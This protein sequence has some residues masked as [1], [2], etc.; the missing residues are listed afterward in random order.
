MEVQWGY[1]ASLNVDGSR[2]RCMEKTKDQQ[3]NNMSVAQLLKG[4]RTERRTGAPSSEARRFR[5]PAK[6]LQQ[7]RQQLYFKEFPS[8]LGRGRSRWKL[9]E[10]RGSRKPHGG[11]SSDETSESN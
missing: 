2:D 9:L 8:T 4:K 3:K 6:H 5:Q 1:G 10:R 11:N 7:Y